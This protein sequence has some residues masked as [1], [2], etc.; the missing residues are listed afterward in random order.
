M[1]QPNGATKT[2][3]PYSRFNAESVLL[4]PAPQK[5]TVLLACL[6]NWLRVL[7]HYAHSK[8]HTTETGGNHG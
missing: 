8:N 1:A 3:K 5:W 7:M 4:R 6:G 2:G